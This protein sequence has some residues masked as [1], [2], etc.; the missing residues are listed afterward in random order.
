MATRLS[1]RGSSAPLITAGGNSDAGAL[2]VEALLE[3]G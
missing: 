3:M 1:G 2:G